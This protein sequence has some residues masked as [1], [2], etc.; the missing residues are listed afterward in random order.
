MIIINGVLLK[1]NKIPENIT[2]SMTSSIALVN[3]EK[4]VNDYGWRAMY[5]VIIININK[6]AFRKI[7]KNIR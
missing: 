3:P 5:G 4:S 2:L 7:K 1:E 6:K